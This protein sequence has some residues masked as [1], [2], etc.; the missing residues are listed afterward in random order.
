MRMDPNTPDYGYNRGVD[1]D[2]RQFILP[3]Q[4]ED[5]AGIGM[6]LG[7]FSNRPRMGQGATNN[8]LAE[9]VTAIVVGT[10]LLSWLTIVFKVYTALFVATYIYYRLIK[11]VASLT[12]R[13]I[14]LLPFV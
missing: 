3:T 14:K 7:M 5:F 10:V 9:A 1:K 2:K 11:P 8:E 12:S 4:D 13:L 6:L